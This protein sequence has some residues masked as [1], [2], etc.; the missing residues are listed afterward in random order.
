MGLN[1]NPYER[2]IIQACDKRTINHRQSVIEDELGSRNTTSSHDKNKDND[3]LMML[4][5]R[6]RC[7]LSMLSKSKKRLE[8]NP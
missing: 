6:W 8:R 5:V 3:H 4:N 1:E 7:Y 2:L